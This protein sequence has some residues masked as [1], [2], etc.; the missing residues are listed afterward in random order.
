M[1]KIQLAKIYK[2]DLFKGYGIAVDG[3][4]LEQQASTTIE[5]NGVNL[6]II[7]PTFILKNEQ[8]ENPIRIQV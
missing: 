1:K 2:G 7:V 6:P 5:S 8:V 4:L 3:E